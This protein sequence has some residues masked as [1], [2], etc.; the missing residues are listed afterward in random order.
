MDAKLQYPDYR[1]VVHGHSL[2]G[3]LA[4]LIAF[5]MVDVH[6]LPGSEIELVTFGAPRVGDE[7]FVKQLEEYVPNQLRVINSTDIVPM[8]PL[9]AM[10]YNHPKWELWLDDKADKL[11]ASISDGK[12]LQRWPALKYPIWKR[13]KSGISDHQWYLG[14]DLTV[15]DGKYVMSRK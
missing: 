12:G 1:L 11:P 5:Q 2:G 6:K 7:A 3:A 10:G 8:L 13:Y 14:A 9:Q 4:T 15:C